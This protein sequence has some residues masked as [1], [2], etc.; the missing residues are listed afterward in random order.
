[1]TGMN[2]HDDQ[3]N[4]QGEGKGADITTIVARDFMSYDFA[5]VTP[6]TPLGDIITHFSKKSCPDLVV[7]DHDGTFRGVITPFDLMTHLNPIIG[8]RTRRKV[9][10]IECMIMGEASV[11]A[12]IMTKGHLT[13]REETPVMEVLRLLEKYHH[14]DLFVVDERGVALG[15][16][17]ICGIISHLRIIGHL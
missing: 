1:M 10:C 6:E 12:D 8:V 3:Q 17:S 9:S 15:V 2:S 5:R 14:P 7:T 13:V 16:V 11:A 4:P